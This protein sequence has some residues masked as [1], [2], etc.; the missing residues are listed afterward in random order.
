MLSN[1]T[2]TERTPTNQEICKE[3]IKK[4]NSYKFTP[5]LEEE[6]NTKIFTSE[7]M[8][9]TIK[10]ELSYINSIKNTA[11]F[12]SDTTKTDKTLKIA[13]RV[14]KGL[15][16]NPHNEVLKQSLCPKENGCFLNCLAH[17]GLFRMPQQQLAKRRRTVIF[18]LRPLFFMSRIM[19]QIA[20][21]YLKHGD[22]VLIRLNGT[23]DYYG[24]IFKLIYS[25]F[26][27]LDF[28]EYTKEEKYFNIDTKRGFNNIS[29]IYSGSNETLELYKET[30][31]QINKGRNVSIAVNS[32]NT[33][34]DNWTPLQNKVLGIIDYDKHDDRTIAT[35][36]EIGF[37][38]SKATNKEE[39][40]S[41]E[42]K[43]HSFFFNRQAFENLLV[44]THKISRFNSNFKLAIKY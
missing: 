16:L 12:L 43:E 3:I 11:Y 7:E 26:F 31:Q 5:I 24:L 8:V 21:L 17:G 18:K 38:S 40:L 41:I 13:G 2:R 25:A 39:R 27:F 14:Q 19:V 44:D 35:Q 30:V 9:D 36:G 42:N 4:Y 33:K 28:N 1:L 23:S 34:S 10:S 6:I 20:R 32:A 29:R 37:L 22:K 15:F